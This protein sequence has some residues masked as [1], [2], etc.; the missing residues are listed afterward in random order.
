MYRIR[1]GISSGNIS[2]ALEDRYPDSEESIKQF[3]IRELLRTPVDLNPPLGE[4]EVMLGNLTG[5][6]LRDLRMYTHSMN[7]QAE[8]LEYAVNRIQHEQSSYLDDILF[9]V[10]SGE[11]LIFET[12]VQAS[13]NYSDVRKNGFVLPEDLALGLSLDADPKTGVA[14]HVHK[15]SKPMAGVGVRQAEL[16]SHFVAIEDAYIETSLSNRE[17][18]FENDSPYNLLDSNLVFNQVIGI[19]EETSG[20]MA[21]RNKCELVVGFKLEHVQDLNMMS[22]DGIAAVACRLTKLEYKNLND[23]WTEIPTEDTTLLNKTNISF[24]VVTAK[25]IR[26]TLEQSPTERGLFVLGKDPVNEV[27]AERE[28][29]YLLEETITEFKGSIYDFSLR[30]VSFFLSSY[31]PDSYYQGSP[32]S[33][34]DCY[35]VSLVDRHQG[36]GYIERW[37]YIY[38]EDQESVVYDGYVPLPDYDY[39]Q[40]E[41]LFP[42]DGICKVKLFPQF[43]TAIQSP[44]KVLSIKTAIFTSTTTVVTEKNHGLV[45]S[46]EV[47]FLGESNLAS[48]YTVT[49]VDSTS[50]TISAGSTFFNQ[51]GMSPYVYAY[52]TNGVSIP[53]AFDVYKDG[54]LLTIGTDYEYSVDSSDSWSSSYSYEL[55]DYNSTRIAGQFMIKILFPDIKC[56]YH[57]QY[58]YHPRQQLDAAGNVMLRNRVVELPQNTKGHA[59]PVFVFR[60]SDTNIYNTLILKSYWTKTKARE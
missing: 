59:R 24:D 43:D 13:Q 19:S 41:L 17:Y 31:Y 47:K 55:S 3:Q 58:V 52:K 49:V 8:Q 20:F 27:L 14:F 50:F 28:F 18:V 29:S 34:E 56:R 21:V 5:E 35:G 22:I 15:N 53:N 32:I 39:L 36:S 6:Y 10:E 2:E 54:V 4:G 33:L 40:K 1:Q 16:S 60:S 42:E 23:V 11:D 25:S 51:E 7:I 44:L 57:V 12:K 45:T 46:D 48:T 38:L 9:A 26:V 30:S 37:M